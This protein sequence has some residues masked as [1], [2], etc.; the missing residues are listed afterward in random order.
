[1]GTL[2]PAGRGGGVIGGGWIVFFRPKNG[3]IDLPFS[4]RRAVRFAINLI[5]IAIKDDLFYL[6][7]VNGA[8]RT[9]ERLE[10]KK[11]L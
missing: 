6:Y 5:G 3:F 11:R 9:C 7:R 8:R 10:S 2:F 4:R 1:M